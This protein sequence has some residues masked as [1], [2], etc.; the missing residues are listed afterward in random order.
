MWRD[1]E[2]DEMGG[3]DGNLSVDDDDAAELEIIG[4]R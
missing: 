4:R 1:R 2:G 3:G